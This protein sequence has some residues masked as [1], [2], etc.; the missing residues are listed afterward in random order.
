[1]SGH[2]EMSLARDVQARAQLVATS[3]QRLGLIHKEIGSEHHSITDDVNLSAL[4][5]TRGD[6]AKH[7]LLSLEFESVTSIRSALE[8]CNN[9][10]TRG[11]YI[12]HL[13][14]S[15]IAPLQSEQ[16]VNFSFVHCFVFFLFCFLS[17]VL[18]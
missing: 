1:M 6:T 4:E 3:L 18:F 13:S 16:D 2:D 5:N 9:I 10:I 17:E 12:D 8:S 15:F 7:I 14:F 11:Q